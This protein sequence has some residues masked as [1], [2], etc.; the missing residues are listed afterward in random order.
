[1]VDLT[2]KE[3]S[4]LSEISQQPDLIS[5]RSL[6]KRTGISIGLINAVLRRI[7][8]KGYVKARALNKKKIRYLLTRKGSLEVMKRAYESTLHTV[9]R[10]RFL[11]D[12]IF[13]LLTGV[14]NKGY[15][16]IHLHGES[17]LAGI[18]QTVLRNH[19]G[20]SLLLLQNL[21]GEQ[22]AVLLNLSE[23]PVK[24]PCPVINLLDHLHPGQE[25]NRVSA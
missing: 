18:V 8:R 10:Y 4:L 19:F 17:E 24:G 25:T 13:S 22:D 7:I 23:M 2:P 15:R 5:Q 3:F 14:H 20:E 21:D 16:K 12:K 9:N 1:M 11:E 6:A